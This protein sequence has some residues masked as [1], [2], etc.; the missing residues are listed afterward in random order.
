MSL[1]CSMFIVLSIDFIVDGVPLTYVTLCRVEVP[2]TKPHPTCPDAEHDNCCK[3]KSDEMDWSQPDWD[4]GMC[5]SACTNVCS[6]AVPFRFHTM[7]L[8][9]RVCAK[10]VVGNVFSL[11]N[12]SFDISFIFILVLRPSEG[13]VIW[14]I[15]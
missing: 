3:C 10:D 9:P 7:V 8:D 14:A 6:E 11:S 1:F 2:K 13:D 4:N 15:V 12:V 5:C